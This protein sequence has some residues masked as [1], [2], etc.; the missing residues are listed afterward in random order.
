MDLA[1]HHASSFWDRKEPFETVATSFGE[2]CCVKHNYSPLPTLAFTVV[3]RNKHMNTN[4]HLRNT[5]TPT[6][7]LLI[8]ASLHTGVFD[9]KSE[10]EM[11]SACWQGDEKPERENREQEGGR[12]G[13][14]ERAGVRSANVWKCESVNRR[15]HIDLDV[16]REYGSWE[17]ERERNELFHSMY[18]RS[19]V[20]LSFV[21]FFY[22]TLCVFVY[23]TLPVK[24]YWIEQNLIE[25]WGGGRK[26]KAGAREREKKHRT[27]MFYSHSKYTIDVSL[28]NSCFILNISL[29]T[30]QLA[31]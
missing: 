1:R 10:R 25:R 20:L 2:C 17:K 8:P 5:K 11:E 28:Y 18:W 14:R 13:R 9:R 24:I 4:M 16:R 21:H 23:I 12:E 7:R 29:S 19:V 31:I 15:R 26:G 30:S 22:F 27:F 6:C 3:W